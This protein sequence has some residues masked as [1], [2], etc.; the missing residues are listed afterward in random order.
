MSKRNVN[1][2][3]LWV[4]L[5][6]LLSFTVVLG[7]LYPLVITA[8]SQV[9]LP[10]QANGSLIQENGNVVGSALIGQAF[11]DKKGMPIPGW[12]QPRPSEATSDDSTD[13]PD[14]GYNAGASGGS[15]LGPNNP[16]L[17]EAI[18][19]RRQ[20]VA[21]DNEV[22]PDQVPVDALTASSSGLDP[23][24]SPEYALLQV[25]RVA[26]ARNMPAGT[27]KSLV[28]SIIQ[29]RDIGILGEPT[30]NV[31]QLNIKL[32]QMAP[33]KLASQKMDG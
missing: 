6:V 9:A 31:L 4:A 20:A 2:R 18:E 13:I 1:T 26:K 17:V 21:R 24:I 8:V 25:N 19:Q 30:V 7:M 15:N 12:F 5:R 29:Q 14:P 10:A 3:Q 11:T 22:S 23:H 16:E 27:V 33:M 32:E 28:E